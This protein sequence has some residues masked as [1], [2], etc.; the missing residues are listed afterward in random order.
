MSACANCGRPDPTHAYPEGCFCDWAC[1]E[2]LALND[3]HTG[4]D[5][6]RR[7]AYLNQGRS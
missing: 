7:M 5:Y 3:P 1:R 2:A 4:A 6:L